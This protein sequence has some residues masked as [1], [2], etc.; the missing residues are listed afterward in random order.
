MKRLTKRLIALTV[1]AAMLTIPSLAVASSATPTP[2]GTV[3]EIERMADEYVRQLKMHNMRLEMDKTITSA[4]RQQIEN[5]INEVYAG[6]EAIGFRKA[7][8]QEVAELSNSGQSNRTRGDLFDD[9]TS[10]NEEFII[11]G[12]YPDAAYGQK[13]YYALVYAIPSSSNSRL[14]NPGFTVVLMDQATT[15]QEQLMAATIQ[16]FAG[17][18]G[19]AITD[20]IPD[21]ITTTVEILD[22]ASI[23]PAVIET[24]SQYVM[25][26]IMQSTV[27]YVY[28]SDDI[29]NFETTCR[30]THITN[31]LE[32]FESHNAVFYT[33]SG[34]HPSQITKEWTKNSPQYSNAVNSG[35]QNY[36]T[37]SH[38][39]DDISIVK[40]FNGEQFVCSVTVGGPL[41]TP[42][43]YGQID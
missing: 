36:V 26:Q 23:N 8:A 21:V 3:N 19:E 20:H 28:V 25:V 10:N 13:L 6:L 22:Q 41:P 43:W 32:V 40:Y 27:K 30:V 33:S 11:G 35:L 12:P 37:G 42:Y 31:S 39:L 38:T 15:S 34:M 16:G 7:T 2:V 5:E 24:I 14:T 1:I 4:K 9:L 17:L 18:V 29:T